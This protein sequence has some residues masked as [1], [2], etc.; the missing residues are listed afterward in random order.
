M[1]L[2]DLLKK[3][4]RID[5]DGAPPMETPGSPPGFTFMRTTTDMQEIIE[6]PSHPSDQPEPVEKEKRK[7]PFRRHS[8]AHSNAST[9]G[10]PSI[11]PKAAKQDRRISD[12]FHIH[13]RSKSSS[14]VNVPS[15]LPDLPTAAKNDEDEG[16]WEKRATVLAQ[17]NSISRPGSS[18]AN[19]DVSQGGRPGLQRTVSVADEG[20]DVR[21]GLIRYT[22][23]AKDKGLTA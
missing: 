6:P 23:G 15:D 14:S 20:G 12:R 5:N 16:Q 21:R 7:S 19:M 8:N 2:K 3:K 13:H 22:F 11:E 1:P 18:A 17:G 4:E 9:N 10:S